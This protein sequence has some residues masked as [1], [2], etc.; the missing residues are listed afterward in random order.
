[1]SKKEYYFV[2]YAHQTGF[3][4]TTIQIEGDFVLRE[5]EKSIAIDCGF[6]TTGDAT[7][8]INNFIKITKKQWEANNKKGN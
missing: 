1:M 8:V 3:G 6:G 5:I 4:R 7:V 2:S